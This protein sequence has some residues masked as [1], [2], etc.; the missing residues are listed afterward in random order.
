MLLNKKLYICFYKPVTNIMKTKKN[1]PRTAKRKIQ[2][3]TVQPITVKDEKIPLIVRMANM[4]TGRVV[5]MS[6]KAA[7]M[8][9]DK[10]PKEFKIL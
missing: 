10:Y 7:S 4:R 5:R 8:L 6:V 9:S 2:P 3:D 1:S